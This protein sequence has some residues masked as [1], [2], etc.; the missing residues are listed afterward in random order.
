MKLEKLPLS[1]CRESR[2]NSAS[3]PRKVIYIYTYTYVYS[4]VRREI[5]IFTT[6]SIDIMSGAEIKQYWPYAAEA[7][8][9]IAEQRAAKST[10]YYGLEGDE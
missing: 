2:K 1:V 9:A 6:Q 3:S 10:G 7:A 4:W 5:D 8:K